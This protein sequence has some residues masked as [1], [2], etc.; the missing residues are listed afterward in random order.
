MEQVLVFDLGEERYGLELGH[1]QEVADAP[2]L[3]YIPQAP[4]YFLGAINFHGQILPVL[5]LCRFLDLPTGPHDP[6][7]IVLAAEGWALALAATAVHR[8]VPL[9]AEAL[10]PFQ[11]SP[12][13]ETF[14]R[15]VFHHQERMINLLD[16][17]RLLQRL[18]TA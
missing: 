5:D 10:L 7:K 4:G 2:G 9:A 8:I 18:E 15:A 14:I 13:R 6:R 11:G 12:G 17:P 1:I 3:H 16:L